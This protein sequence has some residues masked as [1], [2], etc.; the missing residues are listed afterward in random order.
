MSTTFVSLI[1][2]IRNE[3]AHIEHG[4]LAI[5]GQDYHAGCMEILIVDVMS[6]DN[7]RSL[8]HDFS[9]L[10]SQMKIQIMDNPERIV[11]TGMNIAL[12]QAK[13]EIIIRVDGH[14]IIAVD[15]V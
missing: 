2:P 13:G 7:T 9:T 8:I 14:C 4:L 12:R 1:L 5:A 6:I 11:P 3:S 10:H 15:Y